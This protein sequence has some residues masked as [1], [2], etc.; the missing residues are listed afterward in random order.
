MA[1]SKN[2]LE[3]K[4]QYL[5]PEPPQMIKWEEGREVS[6]D[7]SD[8]GKYYDALLT[9]EADGRY[10]MWVTWGVLYPNSSKFDGTVDRYLGDSEAEA[11]TVFYQ[12]V[13]QKLADGY[14]KIVV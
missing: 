1:K 11:R 12:T 9:L 8:I 7:R 3:Q 6:V 10:R 5:Y 14:Y 4:L 2:I 13:A